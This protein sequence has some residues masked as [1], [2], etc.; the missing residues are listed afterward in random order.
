LRLGHEPPRMESNPAWAVVLP[1]TARRSRRSVF[2]GI[3]GEAGAHAVQV[4]IGRHRFERLA[5]GLDE[6]GFEALGPKRAVALVAAVEQTEKRC[7]TSFI[8]WETSP[9]RA[10]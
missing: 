3:A 8:K 1:A 6:D 4:D 5:L 2:F 7:F 10:V 9:M